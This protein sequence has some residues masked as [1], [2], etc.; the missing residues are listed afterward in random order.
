MSD[1]ADTSP[2]LGID[3]APTNE[4]CAGR[5]Y[6]TIYMTEAEIENMDNEYMD[7]LDLEEV[8]QDV[9]PLDGTSLMEPRRQLTTD[10]SIGEVSNILNFNSD[11]V[12]NRTDGENSCEVKREMLSN[13]CGRENSPSAAKV[14]LEDIPF[15]RKLLPLPPLSLPVDEVFDWSS[16][17]KE[18]DLKIKDGQKRRKTAKRN[19]EDCS[20][21]IQTSMESTKKSICTK[22]CLGCEALLQCTMACTQGLDVRDSMEKE[23]ELTLKATVDMNRILQ[24][25]VKSLTLQLGDIQ[26]ENRKTG[27]VITDIDSKLNEVLGMLAHGYKDITADSANPRT[28]G[29]NY[30]QLAQKKNTEVN[31]GQGNT[32]K[33]VTAL[34]R[35]TPAFKMTPGSSFSQKTTTQPNHHRMEETWVKVAK[36]KPLRARLSKDTVTF[37]NAFCQDIDQ[38]NMEDENIVLRSPEEIKAIARPIYVPQAH[39]VSTIRI[40]RV[41]PRPSHGK[42]KYWELFKKLEVKVYGIWFP[43]IDTVEILCATKDRKTIVDYFKSVTLREENPDPWTAREG[44]QTTVEE[45]ERLLERR[46]DMLWHEGN[47][48]GMKHLESTLKHGIAKLPAKLQVRFL[49]KLMELVKMK[50]LQT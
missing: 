9:L 23:L 4:S 18:I 10:I 29:E 17:F 12:I 20:Q 16:Q 14:L 36:R 47:T 1:L 40:P 28:S 42:P 26:R 8:H 30:P 38:T 44:R 49:Q 50:N 2:N 11:I 15:T 3:P 25:Q 32:L 7:L 39:N 45:L 31:P 37:T 13:E 34:P 41:Q 5:V 21:V 48:I 24:K 35:R 27:K 33:A 22:G 46:M 43:K 19:W 6:D